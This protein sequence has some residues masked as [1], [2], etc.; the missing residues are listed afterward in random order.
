M[1]ITVEID[2]ATLRAIKKRT[3][4]DKNSPAI[5]FVVSD[6]IRQKKRRAFL[7]KVLAGQTDYG[8]TNEELERRLYGTTD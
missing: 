5:S 4:I 2:E 8:M 6:W 7:D 3:K 1:R